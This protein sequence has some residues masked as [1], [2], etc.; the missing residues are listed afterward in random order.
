[1]KTGSVKDVQ[2]F[3][4]ILPNNNLLDFAG[5]TQVFHEAMEQ[6]LNLNIN[7]CSFEDNLK[8]SANLPLGKIDSYKRQ[9]VRAGDYIF[10][11][12]AH[13]DYVLSGKM[14]PG[15][16]FT[17]WMVKAYN[18]GANVCAICNGA[19][20][21]GKT[22]LLNGR[23]CTTH[24]KRTAQLQQ[25]FPAAKVQENILFVDDERVITSAGATSGIDV[26]LYILGKLK[27]DNFVYKIARELVIYTRRSGTDMQHS[28]FLN[29]RNHVHAGIHKVQ[30]WLLN[31]L[32]KKAGIADLAQIALMSER[33]FTR[34]FKK[35]IQLTVNE[36]I[37]LLRKEKIKELMKNP[38]LSREQMAKLCGLQSVKQVS[39]LISQL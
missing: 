15:P 9:Q 4:L 17:E 35:E 31:N 8:T 1:M 13:I 18:A 10:I 6:G 22:G 5:A 27:D 28:L 19:F 26:A 24:W 30:D 16:E 14:D 11:V 39:R 20:L 37:T 23:K 38:D 3:F 32:H 34:V 33:N 12:S 25:R 2:I 29:Y 36:Y 7:F 21:L